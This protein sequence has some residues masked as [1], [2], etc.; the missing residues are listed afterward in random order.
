MYIT[1]GRYCGQPIVLACDGQCGKAWGINCRPRFY[2]SP[3]PD[4]IAMFADHELGVAPIDPGTYEG[5]HMKPLGPA[6]G[7]HNKWCCRECERCV[8]LRPDE[9]IIL[10]DFSQRSYNAEP[11]QRP[12]D[13]GRDYTVKYYLEGERGSF[14]LHAATR[15]AAEAI[16]LWYFPNSQAVWLIAPGITVYPQVDDFAAGYEEGSN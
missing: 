5:G 12:N 6:D 8:M 3:D 4:D 13:P 9:D 15:E 10:P 14:Y 2:L 11:H 1:N 7:E 16:A